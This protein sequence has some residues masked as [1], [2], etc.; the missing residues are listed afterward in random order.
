M[1]AAAGGPVMVAGQYL[2]VVV[3]GGSIALIAC[4]CAVVSW[5]DEQAR[6][7]H[8]WRVERQTRANA[9]AA[10]KWAGTRKEGEA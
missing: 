8:V 9:A 4:I 2:G 10:R 7:R 1:I 5:R 3:L 6:R